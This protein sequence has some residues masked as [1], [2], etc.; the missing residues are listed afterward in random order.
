MCEA[1]KKT[2]SYYSG[3]FDEQKI[4]EDKLFWK[5]DRPFLSSKM[6]SND[7]VTIE[8]NADVISNTNEACKTLNSFFGNFT[9]TSRV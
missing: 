1:Y 3:K 9:K 4:R 2:K 8:A 5:T 6:V 7:K